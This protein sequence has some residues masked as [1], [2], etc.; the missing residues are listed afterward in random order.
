MTICSRS[1]S[2]GISMFEKRNISTLHSC[3]LSRD[4]SVPPDYWDDEEDCWAVDIDGERYYCG[5]EED[6]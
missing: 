4:N 5:R 6:R 2:G 1:M 3:Q